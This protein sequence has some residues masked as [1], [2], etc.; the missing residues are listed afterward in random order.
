MI[1]AV[2]RELDAK[3]MVEG[4][5]RMDAHIQ[6]EVLPRHRDILP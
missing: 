3:A 4:M 5:K 6:R 1:A 2:V